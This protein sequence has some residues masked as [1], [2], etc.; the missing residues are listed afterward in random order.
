MKCRVSSRLWSRLAVTI[1]ALAAGAMSSLLMSSLVMSSL[2]MS[3]LGI[4]AG[5][6]IALGSFL[7]LVFILRA[8]PELS[9]ATARW[10][11]AA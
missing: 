1:L 3:S 9:L 11:A 7:P 10:P 8:G 4:V 2:V 6:G 5:L